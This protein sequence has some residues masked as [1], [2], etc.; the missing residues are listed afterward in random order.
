MAGT[1]RQH[2]I[3]SHVSADDI[4]LLLISNNFLHNDNCY[5]QLQSA[6]ERHAKTDAYVFAILIKPVY[7]E[8]T[9]PNNIPKLPANRTPITRSSDRNQAYRDVVETIQ[10]AV[11][12]IRTEQ[13][14]K[15]G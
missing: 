3:D 10:K 14:L 6:S 8:N 4:I 13:W 15:K 12:E 1:E 7:W 2:E 9:I 5:N 11:N